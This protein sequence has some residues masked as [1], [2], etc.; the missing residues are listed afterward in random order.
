MLAKNR[1]GHL[2]SRRHDGVVQDDYD[3]TP[4]LAVGTVDN[5]CLSKPCPA[6]DSDLAAE[7]PCSLRTNSL[8]LQN[9]SLFY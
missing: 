8:F 4:L 6:D 5:T 2:V 9:N 1:A 7:I 3:G